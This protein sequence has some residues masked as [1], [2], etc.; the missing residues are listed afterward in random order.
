MGV[1]WATP[2]EC[3]RFWQFAVGLDVSVF[4]HLRRQNYSYIAVHDTVIE[5]RMRATRRQYRLEFITRHWRARPFV[6]GLGHDK[7]DPTRLCLKPL[8]DGVMGCE[9]NNLCCD[10]VQASNTEF[11]LS[12][13]RLFPRVLAR[14]I[15]NLLAVAVAAVGRGTTNTTVI[16][17]FRNHP[18]CDFRNL[19]QLIQ[20]Y[21]VIAV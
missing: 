6:H 7:N 2:E 12:L 21:Y 11:Y 16:S 17:R 13:K 19:W 9:C 20:Y 3:L 15:R 14:Y 8:F 5:V 4:E 1:T 18:L 10:F